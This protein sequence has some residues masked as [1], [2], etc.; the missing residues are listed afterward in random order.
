MTK[1]PIPSSIAFAEAVRLWLKL[2]FISFAGL[3]LTLSKHI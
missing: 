3:V 2:E 1:S